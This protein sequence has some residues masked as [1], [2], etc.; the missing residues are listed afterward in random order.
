MSERRTARSPRR[1]GTRDPTLPPGLGFTPPLRSPPPRSVPK[2]PPRPSL[3]SAQDDEAKPSKGTLPCIA[4][5]VVYHAVCIVALLVWHAKVHH[6]FNLTHALL[7][8]FLVINVW[9]CICEIAL[10][11][12]PGSIPQSAGS[13]SR[14]LLFGTRNGFALGTQ[15]SYLTLEIIF[16][17][18]SLTIL[19]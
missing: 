14:E 15:A 11:C 9:I 3:L 2:P 6:T 16:R 17:S 18:R 5:V 7:A 19:S 13:I 8:T 12:L 1:K 10:L 4:Y